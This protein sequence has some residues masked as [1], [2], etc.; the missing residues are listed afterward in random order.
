MNGSAPYQHAVIEVIE[1][2]APSMPQ[3]G[4]R[5][6]HQRG[7]GRGELCFRTPGGL[8]A[9]YPAVVG[10]D[11]HHRADGP[12]RRR[13]VRLAEGWEVVQ[14]RL[15]REAATAEASDLLERE[16]R[17]AL[18]VFRAYQDSRHAVLFP[19]LAGYDLDADE[20]FVLYPERSFTPLPSLA[21]S[22]SLDQQ[23]GIGRDLVLMVRL[24][25]G[26]GL[27]H[28]GLSPATLGWENGRIRLLDLSGQARVGR[29]RTPFGQPPW[30]SPEQRAGVGDADAR[31]ALWSVAQLMYYLLY[32][33]PG[34]ADGM[35]PEFGEDRT[36]APVLAPA[37]APRAEQRPRP[38]ALLPLLACP[39]PFQLD[40]PLPDPLDPGRQ[41]FDRQLATKRRDLGLPP[42]AMV[43]PNRQRG[44]G[45]AGGGRRG[46]WP[47]GGSRGRGAR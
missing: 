28:R 6:S 46:R 16:I 27:V 5:P 13:T 41:E 32:G 38:G 11:E 25:E 9:Q 22:A 33:R 45:A 42:P 23:R 37:F 44:A 47:F 19:M 7:K 31:D 12:F 26:V 21:G 17:G 36:V 14:R 24:L 40:P 35:A 34:D 39:D 30:A 10:P 29:P 3:D 43:V 20:P 2:E 8:Q 18:V 4:R 1:Q 15:P